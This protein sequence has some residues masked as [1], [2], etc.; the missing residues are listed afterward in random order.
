M[1]GSPTDKRL[2]YRACR[3]VFSTRLPRLLG[4][5]GNVNTSNA[6]GDIRSYYFANFGS[7]PL[8][9]IQLRSIEAHG[10][11]HPYSYSMSE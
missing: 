11:L 5:Y 10:S 8:V 7:S 6:L 3:Y 9:V 1:Q 2:A 4:T